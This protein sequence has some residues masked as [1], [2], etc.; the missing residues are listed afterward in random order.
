[1][2]NPI[3]GVRHVFDIVK[4]ARDNQNPFSDEMIQQL[5]DATVSDEKIRSRYNNFSKGYSA[6][7]LF[8]RIFSLLPWVRLITPLG[9]EQ[10]PEV[11]KQNLQT[12]DYEI[13]YEVGS[14]RELKKFL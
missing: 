9:Q 1:M 5:L 7:E 2:T 14:Q 3:Q 11:S 10:Y 12:P 13:T 4:A 8:R 6:E